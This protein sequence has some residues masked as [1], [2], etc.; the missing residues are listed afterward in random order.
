MCLI[1]ST[2][3]DTDL[4]EQIR[5]GCDVDIR[6]HLS[7]RSTAFVKRAT[8]AAAI[9]DHVHAG[10]TD[11]HRERALRAWEERA[12][13]RRPLLSAARRKRR[14]GRARER[15]SVQRPDPA[16]TANGTATDDGRCQR[17]SRTRP[18]LFRVPRRT[19]RA[20]KSPFGGRA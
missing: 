10:H 4:D 19:V 17:I 2:A 12:S 16:A 11:G 8:T 18:F 5:T 3:A 13:H 6:C 1:S 20:A 9:G 15:K 7:S 14:G